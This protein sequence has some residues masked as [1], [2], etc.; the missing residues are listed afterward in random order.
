MNQLQVALTGTI[1]LTLTFLLIAYGWRLFNLTNTSYNQL[2]R[3]RPREI[4]AITTVIVLIFTTRSIDDFLSVSSSFRKTVGHPLAWFDFCCYAFWEI[5]PTMMVLIYFRRI[6]KTNFNRRQ[7][8]PVAPLTFKAKDPPP[9]PHGLSS[10]LWDDPQ[11][12]DSDEE[13]FVR[14]PSW[15]AIYGTSAGSNNGL[16]HGSGSDS[17]GGLGA[18]LL[19][20]YGRNYS[21][22][23]LSSLQA[24]ARPGSSDSLS[25]TAGV[26]HAATQS[27]S[28]G[29]GSAAGTHVQYLV[30]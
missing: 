22:E 9:R 19:A 18:A 10:R 24:L 16:P 13:H 3:I 23:S 1:F 12:Y 2:I 20:H 7:F 29:S 21:S 6:P 8:I 4:V 28:S 26:P 15:S 14:S 11:R 30:P 25:R 5:T 17:G 27:A